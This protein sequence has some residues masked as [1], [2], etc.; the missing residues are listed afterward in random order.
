MGRDILR[1]IKENIENRG[2]KGHVFVDFED[3]N[4]YVLITPD[5]VLL[6]CKMYTTPDICMLTPQQIGRLV[7]D[8]YDKFIISQY[9][10]VDQ[11]EKM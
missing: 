7:K 10:S 2:I 1:E 5:I 6:W 11:P 4:L 8:D 9:I 3:G